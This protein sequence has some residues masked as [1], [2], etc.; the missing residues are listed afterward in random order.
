[1]DVATHKSKCLQNKAIDI[2]P[3]K[4]PQKVRLRCSNYC[5][6]CPSWPRLPRSRWTSPARTLAPV[7]VAFPAKGKFLTEVQTLSSWQLPNNSD[8]PFFKRPTLLCLCSQGRRMLLRWQ[9]RILLRGRHG[10]CLLPVP[11]HVVHSKRRHSTLPGT[12][13]PT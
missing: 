2:Y 4:N 6:F 12:M 10:W 3:L 11:A 13:L 5:R 8:N 9:F 1:M 7:V